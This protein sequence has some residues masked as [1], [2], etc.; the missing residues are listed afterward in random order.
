MNIEHY[1]IAVIGAGPAGLSAAACAAEQGANTLLLDEQNSLGGQIYRHIELSSDLQKQRLGPD[2]ASGSEVS[3]RFVQSGAVHLP[4]ARVWSL[5][6]SGEIGISRKQSATMVQARQTIIATGAL[7][8]PIPFP[9]WDLPGVMHAGAGQILFKAHQ[10]VPSKDVVLAGSGPLLLL[11]AWQYLQ[12]GLKVQAILDLT[13]KANHINA[14]KQLPS[15][16]L[17]S[18]YLRKG[19]YYRWQLHKAGIPIISGVKQ[20]RANGHKHI[21]SVSFFKDGE[22]KSLE[23]EHLLVHFGVIPNTNL[24]MAAGCQ[25]H[26]DDAQQCWRPTLNKWGQSS[27]PGIFITGDG[28]SIAGAKSAAYSGEIA[29]IQALFTLGKITIKQ[30]DELALLLQVSLKKDKRIRPFLESYFRIPAS[31]FA[32]VPEETTICRCEEVTAGQIHKTIADGHI[33][34]NQVK[35]LTRCG[36]GP[37]QGRQCGQAVAHIVAEKTGTSVIQAGVY[38]ARPPVNRLTL[39][40]LSSLNS[41]DSN[42]V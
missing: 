18:Q 27:N 11:L 28:A 7:E 31:A 26:W 23:T 22:H 36:M 37:C 24:S 10:I 5:S 16:L 13:P 4:Q 9:G 2:Y 35:F 38:R 6:S 8:R 41:G 20:M 12:V 33:D 17:A 15:A 29:A 39:G 1:D 25:H 32:E 14:I 30:R 34:S 19:L 3:K 40:E 21:S 42:E